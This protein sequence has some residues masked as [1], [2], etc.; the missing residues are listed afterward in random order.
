VT[1]IE[2]VTSFDG[3]PI[4]V[5]VGGE[6]A[7]LVMVHG[8]GSDRAGFALVRPPLERHFTVR[9]MDR[10]GRGQSGD[11]EG[12]ALEREVADV[13][14]VVRSAG[15]GAA[16]FG[17]SWG[18]TLALEASVRLEGLAAVVL[19]EPT[20]GGALSTPELIA[21]LDELLAR[22]EREALALAFLREGSRLG[23]ADI[24]SLRTSPAWPRRVAA[25][26]TVPRELRAEAAWSLEPDRFGRMLSPTLMLLWSESPRWA[27]EATAA[28]SA[29]LPDCQVVTFEGHGHTATVTAP[30]RLA[31][32]V[33]RFIE[34]G[35]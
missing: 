1:T 3:T 25:A 27:A 29:A 34:S 21:R 35:P 11:G 4:A 33:I 15:E 19:Y 26:H 7:P 6:G 31:S 22:D 14:A 16:L 28:V 10:R 32:D 13:V 2:R 5:E 12:Y 17:H 18:A 20:P 24:E 8:A 9:A 30:R 23:E